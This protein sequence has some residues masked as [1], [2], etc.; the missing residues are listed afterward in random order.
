MCNATAPRI[1]GLNDDG[2]VVILVEGELL[3]ELE[4]E[5][6]AGVAA[7]PERAL[8]LVEDKHAGETPGEQHV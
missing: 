5:A 2:N 8:S 4:A 7:C 6:A 3:P 1:F